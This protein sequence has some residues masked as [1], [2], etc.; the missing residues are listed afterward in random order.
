MSVN[1]KQKKK[2]LIPITHQ[3]FVCLAIVY[4]VSSA[5]EEGQKLYLTTPLGVLFNKDLNNK[6][7]I[8]FKTFQREC[9]DTVSTTIQ[10]KKK[11]EH[12]RMFSNVYLS[13]C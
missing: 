4:H 7:G 2:H 6:S 3:S 10:N 8:S 5:Y 12:P 1:E 11:Y 13:K 9:Q